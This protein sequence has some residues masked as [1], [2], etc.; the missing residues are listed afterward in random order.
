MFPQRSVLEFRG[1]GH[2]GRGIGLLS[3]LNLISLPLS[4]GCASLVDLTILIDASESIIDDDPYEKPLYN[5]NR[6]VSLVKGL[7]N[8]LPISG[9]EATRTRVQVVTYSDQSHL[10]LHLDQFQT[11]YDII[12]YLDSNLK[13][14]GGEKMRKTREQQFINSLI[15][16][17]EMV[18]MEDK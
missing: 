16:R 7:V 13:H 3:F 12:N 4:S 14:I 11:A 9:D 8:D 10:V 2:H 1:T 5:W 15:I 6:V 18:N 17:R